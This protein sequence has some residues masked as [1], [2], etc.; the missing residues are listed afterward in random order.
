MNQTLSLAQ[1]DNGI[2]TRS[3]L[4]GVAFDVNASGN[5]GTIEFYLN[6]APISSG[7]LF[8]SMFD[9][10]QIEVLRGPQGTLRGRASPSGSI[11]VTTR[12]PNLSSVGGYM[13]GTANDLGGWNVNG[14]FN[15]PVLED[16]L[17]VRVAGIVEANRDNRV[18][19]LNS[20]VR[21]RGETQGIRASVLFEPFDILTMG[22]VYTHT[23]RKVTTFD[24]VESLPGAPVT[25][26][27]KDRAARMVT[28]RNY[29]QNFEV[30][31]WNGE[32][33]LASQKLNYVGSITKQKIDSLGP[34]DIGGFFGPAF[35]ERVT[36]A[37]LTTA[38]GS[39]QENH[40]VRLSNDE[41]IAGIFDYV[42]GYLYNN[43]QSP[44]NLLSDTLIF[45]G[46]P[47]AS[48]LNLAV[49]NRTPIFR[50]GGYV[51]NSYFGNLTAH[52]GDRTEISGGIR[53][54]KGHSTGRLV[55][56][57]NLV[58]AS[59]EDRKFSA[60]IYSLSAKHRFSDQ[61]MVYASY[62][63]SWRPG[64]GTNSVIQ[65]DN[66]APTAAQAALLFPDPEKSKS[67]EAGIKTDLLDNRLRL[68]VTA[69]HQTFKNFQYFARNIF[70]RGVAA[71]GVPTVFTNITG[72]AVGVPAKVDG[73]EGE[74]AFK[75]SDALSLGAV[76]S[77][78]KSKIKNGRVPCN[79]FFPADGKPDSS[80]QVPTLAN[81]NADGI[82]FC[83]INTRAGLG[84][85]FTA[86]IQGE[87]TQ[88][89]TNGA[90]G[91]LRTLI[92]YNGKSLNDAVNQVDDIKAYSTVNLFA[93]LRDPDGAWEVGA[94]VKNLFDSF[95]VTRR[96]NAA[97]S[98]GYR[99]FGGA[100]QGNTL[101]RSIGV[102]APREFGVTAR[103]AFGS[104]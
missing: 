88:P 53:K 46:T 78:S 39:T 28:P 15:V 42:V 86:T 44:T 18:R 38:T 100:Q 25:I 82:A 99:T 9:V 92:S 14:A 30:F 76:L 79:D 84:A 71:G 52:I 31:N 7:V 55:I 6:D 48:P 95:R 77:Y 1:N 62:G 4:R 94:Y 50:D 37:G 12:K 21:P 64:S 103:F 43:L 96:D 40:E 102:T 27:P 89:V 36:A 8:Q 73:V 59:L 19:S 65:R 13:T 22:F 58:P 26:L 45:T 51:E 56:A 66:T 32:L 67:V 17:A 72:I 101:Y 68:N 34:V 47:S 2:G 80:T 90:D 20:P 3:T 60:T 85:P 57:G 23:D 70:L 11:T 74:I 16:K 61:V 29:R 75:A 10:G 41:R 87:F 93:G 49:L 97:A 63:T 24:Q 69:Y 83:N 33:R 54:I 98:T 91:Y 35:P 5:N 81:F 104:R